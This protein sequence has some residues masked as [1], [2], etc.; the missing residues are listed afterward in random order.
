MKNSNRK[1]LILSN[2]A[3]IETYLA[4]LFSRRK[5]FLKIPGDPVWE[6]SK[7]RGWTN[8]NIEEFQSEKLNLIQRIFRVLINLS[9]KGVCTMLKLIVVHQFIQHQTLVAQ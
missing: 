1:T 5:Y 2:G 9:L 4:C 6:L 7:N 8:N 3:F